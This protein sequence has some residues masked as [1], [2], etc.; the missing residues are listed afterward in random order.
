LPG[1]KKTKPDNDRRPHR[2]GTIFFLCPFN[3]LRRLV[4][5]VRCCC[6]Q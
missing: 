2:P 6:L 4:F 3:G 1:Q 5:F